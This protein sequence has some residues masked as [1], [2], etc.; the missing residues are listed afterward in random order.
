L[1]K[2]LIIAKNPN[3]QDSATIQTFDLLLKSG[4]LTRQD[5]QFVALNQPNLLQVI[6]GAQPVVVVPL[7][8]ECLEIL[9]GEK[10]DLMKIA[11]KAFP[12]TKD[13]ISFLVIPTVSLSYLTRDIGYLSRAQR[14]WEDIGRIANGGSLERPK[15]PT[16]Y[17]FIQDIE[18]ARKLFTRMSKCKEISFDLETTGFN[19]QTDRILCWSFSWQPYTAVVLPILGF[20]EEEIWTPEDKNEIEM[21]LQKLFNNPNIEWIAHNI[22][23]DEKFLIQRNIHIAGPIH[24]TMLLSTIIDENAKDLK[25][26]KPL[27]ELYTDLGD[28]DAPLDEFAKN[29]KA[30]KAQE[31]HDKVKTVTAEIKKLE[32]FIEKA[33]P[34]EVKE[35]KNKVVDLACDLE[36]LEETPLEFSYADIPTDILWPYAAMDADATFRIFQMFYYE[37]L[38]YASDSLVQP[39]GKNMVK[40]YRKLVMPLRKVLND[41]EFVGAQL[42]LDYLKK[43][44]GEYTDKTEQTEQELFSMPEIKQVEQALW[45][46]AG[47]KIGLRYDGLKKPPG[48]I[49]RGVYIQKYTKPVKFNINSS[50]H[51]RI[52][53]YG[54]LK[55]KPFK[56]TPKG[57]PS[58]DKEVLEKLAEDEIHPAISKFQENRKLQKLHKT[59]VKGMQKRVDLNG[60]VHTDFNQHIT[61]TGRL[62]SSKPNLQNIPR[63]NKD[64]KRAFIT[65]PGWSLI[66]A[67]YSQAEFRFWAQLSQDA[68]MISDITAGMDIHKVTA[69]EFWGIP[70]DQVTKDQRT[71]AKFVVFGLMYGRGAES[72]AKQVKIRKDEAE[73]IIKNFFAKYPTAARWLQITRN[74]ATAHGFVFNHFGRIRR[75][76][77]INSSDREKVAEAE[78]QAVNAPIQGSAADMTGVAL[79]RIWKQLRNQNLKARLILTVH[80]SIVLECPNGEL[81]QTV[82]ICHK[83]MTSPIEGVNVPMEIEIEV[84]KNWADVEGWPIE[85][86]SES[87]EKYLKCGTVKENK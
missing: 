87:C 57:D 73:A 36:E 31:H 1:S 19:F 29:L 70:V 82:N 76:P 4:N 6:T 61:V 5:I 62:S 78:R 53:I 50:N 33:S 28:Y 30:E 48:G 79:I 9:T 44:D 49:S 39:Y 69:S 72:V 13:D 8:S 35:L 80:D 17:V 66:Q 75:L 77:H 37:K 84:G 43:L 24:D 16:S 42:D 64:I 54:I 58:T 2:V 47:Q 40:L 34:I 15:K 12:F 71:A 56:F 38:Q 32:K 86:F 63:A 41:I 67:D 18:K 52:L 27:A 14:H 7:G 46:E 59:Y 21:E 85:K 20:K 45:Q 81:L 83:C 26:L 55:V 22:S 23:F 74:F 68:D 25:G 51:L 11:G 60:R 3:N 10:G 65:H